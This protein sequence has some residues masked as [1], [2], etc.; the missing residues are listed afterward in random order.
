MHKKETHTWDHY[1]NI[2]YLDMTSTIRYYGPPATGTTRCPLC[3]N[4]MIT[5]YPD[6]TR[7]AGV[8]FQCPNCYEWLRVKEVSGNEPPNLSKEE[9]KK[10]HSVKIVPLDKEEMERMLQTDTDREIFEWEA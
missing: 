4:L 5:P 2:S 6:K 10:W 7:E 8:A 9:A 1:G 3:H